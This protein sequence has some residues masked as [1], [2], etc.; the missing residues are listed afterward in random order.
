MVYFSKIGK[1]QMSQFSDKEVILSVFEYDFRENASADCFN[2]GYGIDRNFYLAAV[3][4]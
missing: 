2:I 1:S 4:Q 3:Y